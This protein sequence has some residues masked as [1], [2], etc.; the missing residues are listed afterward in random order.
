MATI[1]AA[2]YSALE[3]EHPATI[4]G[5][6]YVLVSRGVIPKTEAAYKSTVLRLAGEMRKAGELPYGWLADNT[7]MMRKPRSYSGVEDVLRQTAQ[8][9]RRSLWNDADAY[10][11]VW[12]EKDAISG[13]LFDVT[14]T[15]DVPLMVT[16]GYPS[17]TFLHAAAETI[18]YVGKPVHLFYFGDHDPSGVDIPRHVE[19][20]I[21]AMAP[22]AEVHFE[23]VAVTEAQIE[24]YGLQ[25]RPTKRTDTRSKGFVGESVEVD[26]IPPSTLRSLAESKIQRHVD[27]HQLATLVAAEES[28]RSSLLALADRWGRR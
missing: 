15:W 3:E 1:K 22:A 27:G 24:G 2:I 20:E 9:Y 7:R 18:S 17:I 6:Y 8:L 21:R 25:T 26:A 19:K 13:V 28:E 12:S 16:R 11:E 10:V 4:R 14:Y 23:R 5:L